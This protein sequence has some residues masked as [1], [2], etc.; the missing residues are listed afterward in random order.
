VRPWNVLATSAEGQ[1]DVLLAALR[2]L[3][4]FRGGGYRNVAIGLVDAPLAFL[5]RVAEALATSRALRTALA[6]LI[7]IETVVPFDPRD[8]TAA[9]E[10]ATAPF[11]DRLAAGP[12]FVRVERR[13]NKGTVHSADI[14]RALGAHVYEALVA[15]GHTPKVSFGQAHAVLAI[16]MLGDTAGLS[17][18]PRS[19]TDHHPFV[20]IR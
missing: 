14:E 1:R 18:I 11:I 15:R 6:R 17:V 12:F 8:P 7:P 3:G 20:R 19:L 10:P 2:R 13:G 16:E 5:D 9:L 4:P